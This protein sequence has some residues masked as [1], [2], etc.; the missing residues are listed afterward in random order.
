VLNHREA[1]E[2]HKREK[3]ISGGRLTPS[4]IKAFLDDYVI[5][6]EKAKIILSNA[7]YNHYKRIRYQQQHKNDKGAIEIDKSNVCM[8]GPTGTGRK[9]LHIS[10]KHA[11]ICLR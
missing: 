3:Q 2:R 4:K 5:G 8:I 11:T 10:T 7:V 9:Q 6:Q 1:I